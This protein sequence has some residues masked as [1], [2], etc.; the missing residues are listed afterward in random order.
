MNRRQMILLT[1][2]A[3]GA[4]IASGAV[5]GP[6]ISTDTLPGANFAQYKT[7]AWANTA[8]PAGMD[9]VAFAR[10]VQDIEGMMAR[11]GYAKV[12]SNPDLVL[13]LSLGAQN[14][15]DIN[16][17]GFFGQ[18]LD[19]YQYTEGHLSLDAF[20]AKTKQA[21]WHGQAAG[22]IHPNK[23]NPAKAEEAIEKMMNKFPASG[24]A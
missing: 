10:I 17:F 1:G 20:D 13:V 12:A 18:Q 16:S 23:P 9:P 24:T 14:K 5:A 4:A 22:T 8:P 15:T 6:K 7:F 11:K 19:V 2:A 3:F 21:V